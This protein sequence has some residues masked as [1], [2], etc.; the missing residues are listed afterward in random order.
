MLSPQYID[1][2]E[3][4][5]DGC[6]DDGPCEAKAALRWLAANAN[7]YSPGLQTQPLEPMAKPETAKCFVTFTMRMRRISRSSIAMRPGRID[8][9]GGAGGIRSLPDG[10]T[11]QEL[12]EALAAH[13]LCRKYAGHLLITTGRDR[14]VLDTLL[15]HFGPH[16]LSLGYSLTPCISGSR[17][18]FITVRKDHRSWVICY[19]ETV[20]GVSVDTLL[21]YARG[22]GALVTPYDFRGHPLALH[23][24]LAAYQSFLQQTFGVALHPTVGMIALKCARRELPAGFHKWRPTP[25]LVAMERI[26]KGYRGGMTYAVRYKGPSWRIDVNRQ[27]TAALTTQLPYRTAFGRY[28]SDESTPGIFVCTLRMRDAIPYPVGVWVGT[29][30]ESRVCGPGRYVCV[31]HTS[32]LAGLRSIGADVSPYYGYVYTHC[33]SFER[34]VERLQRL[35][36]RDGRDSALSKLVKPLGNF[37]YGKLG[38]NPIRKEL[39]FSES[40][41]DASWF[42]YMDDELRMWGSIWERTRNVVT[43]S[44]HVEIAGTVTAA[45]RSQTLQTWAYLLSC[46]YQV[47]RCHTDSLTVNMDP[48]FAMNLSTDRIGDWRV[49]SSDVDT[50]IVGANAYIDDKGAHIAGV[51]DP[52]W[53]MIEKVYDSQVV[54]VVEQQ[55]APLRGFTRAARQVRRK[56]GG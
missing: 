33:F 43:S 42:P 10:L 15:E 52:T 29:G 47:V 21:S 17:I 1:T 32:E 44:Q 7:R 55:N 38:Q 27:Y 45:A 34:Y 24:A 39:L 25:L 23:I 20:S 41:P 51:S 5:E 35:C 18:S 3:P 22:A 8:W 56:Y 13:L 30:F 40:K 53:E 49:E 28:E 54:Y 4:C 36:D 9:Y 16:L 12:S 48:S 2:L 11:V 31:L 19:A 6:E 26:G 50:V 46:G 14:S 37:V